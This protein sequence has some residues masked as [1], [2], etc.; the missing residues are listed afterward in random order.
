MRQLTSRPTSLLV[1]NTFLK[2]CLLHVKNAQEPGKDL[3]MLN[4]SRLHI[5]TYFYE[6]T[7]LPYWYY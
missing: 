2:I 1:P 7:Q 5:F 3:E 4:M 6:C